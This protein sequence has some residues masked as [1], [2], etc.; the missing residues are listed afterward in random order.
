MT[1]ELRNGEP[2]AERNEGRG[3]DK[4]HWPPSENWPDGL[5]IQIYDDGRV[6]IGA[7]HTTVTVT[8]VLNR[9]AGNSKGSSHIVA[10]FRPASDHDLG[11][12]AD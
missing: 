10:R 11:E 3:F 9:G 5:R 6:K 4:Y 1:G 12:D 2:E 7:W 8:D